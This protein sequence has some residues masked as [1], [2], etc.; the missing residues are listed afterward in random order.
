MNI[1][2]SDDLKKPF[3][4]ALYEVLGHPSESEI[5]LIFEKLYAEIVLM[6]GAFLSDD[7]DDS[8]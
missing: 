5:A 1:L 8:D 7:L 4:K 6:I 2:T 3:D